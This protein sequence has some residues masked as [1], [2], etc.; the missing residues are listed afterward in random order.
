MDWAPLWYIL[1]GVVLV[2]IID[3]INYKMTGK[4]WFINNKEA[5]EE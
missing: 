4:S 1:A 3:W 5:N 2:R